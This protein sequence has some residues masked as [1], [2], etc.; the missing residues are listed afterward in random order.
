MTKTSTRKF[1]S[2]WESCLYFRACGKKVP[3][4]NYVILNQTLR[5]QGRSWKTGL[6]HILG[7]RELLHTS[8]KLKVMNWDPTLVVSCRIIL[9]R[10]SSESLVER[11][12]RNVIQCVCVCWRASTL[13]NV[14]YLLKSYSYVLLISFS[15]ACTVK[16]LQLLWMD[17]LSCLWWGFCTHV[18]Y[19]VLVVHTVAM[20]TNVTF[21]PHS[22]FFF[23]ALSANCA[24][25]CMKGIPVEALGIYRNQ[26]LSSFNLKERCCVLSSPI[27]YLAVV[28]STLSVNCTS[29]VWYILHESPPLGAE[30]SDLWLRKAHGF[31]QS[32][33]T[34]PSTSTGELKFWP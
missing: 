7:L 13:M 27:C 2:W 11:T 1:V 14:W 15:F 20:V 24:N 29:F 5:A 31:K 30:F 21:P 8:W 17:F 4:P 10:T 12:K 26:S 25:V 3:F 23:A 16:G 33:L 28:F 22:N 18:V 6:L 9:C 34:I 19:F 32:T